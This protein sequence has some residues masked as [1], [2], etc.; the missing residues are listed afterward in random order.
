MH[1]KYPRILTNHPGIY[2]YLDVSPANPKYVQAWSR[3]AAAHPEPGTILV[4]DRIFCEFNADS[5]YVAKLQMVRD[6]GWMEDR[7]AEIA[8]GADDRQLG[9]DPWHIFRSPRDIES[10]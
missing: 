4:W 2:F 9:D 3:E 8:S 1:D 7:Q 6:A 5:T 10:R